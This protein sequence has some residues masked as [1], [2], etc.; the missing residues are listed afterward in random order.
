LN[1][2]FLALLVSMVALL[3]IPAFWDDQFLGGLPVAMLFSIV[4]LAGVWAAA[5]SPRVLRVGLLL[6]V[7]TLVLRWYVFV[8][9]NETTFL[10]S[11]FATMSFL[12]F[13]TG[14]VLRAV[15]RHQEVSL[16]T[17]SGGVCVYFLLGLAWALAY[18]MLEVVHPGSF[19]VRATDLG[20][21]AF[22]HGWL[23]DLLYLSFVTLSTLGYGDLTPLS[24]PAKVLTVLEAIVG[25]LFLAILI[26]RLVGMHIAQAR[27][28]K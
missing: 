23:S 6:A 11:T 1:Q 26:G 12:L 17:I 2:P 24:R 10:V 7:P 21:S 4:M 25:Q 14:V 18:G 15:L 22:R 27:Q 8:D 13:T 16:D 9:A 3:V 19:P 20:V 28:D 5:D